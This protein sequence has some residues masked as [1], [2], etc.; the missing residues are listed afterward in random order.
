MEDSLLTLI[1]TYW[2]LHRSQ[3]RWKSTWRGLEEVSG[4]SRQLLVGKCV[5]HGSPV[6]VLWLPKNPSAHQATT[7]LLP[8]RVHGTAQRAPEPLERWVQA[9][10][11]IQLQGAS[12]DTTSALSLA[13]EMSVP[14]P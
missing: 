8:V 7:D 9:G 13:L 14:P 4:T 1:E 2:A 5:I 6:Q 10:K 12:G 3:K 11:Q